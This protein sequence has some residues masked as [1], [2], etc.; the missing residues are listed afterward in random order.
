MNQPDS[1]PEENKNIKDISVPQLVEIHKF[2]L[3]ELQSLVQDFY[4]MP[5]KSKYVF[6]FIVF[7]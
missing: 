1:R 2:M 4:G 6:N 5:D 3:N 7:T